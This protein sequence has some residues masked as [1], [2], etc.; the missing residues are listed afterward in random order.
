MS[1]DEVREPGRE[2][3]SVD[4]CIVKA[5]LAREA[6]GRNPTDREKKRDETQFGRRITQITRGRNA[7][8]GEQA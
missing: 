8:R 3:Q 7:Q 6:V 2:Q 5:P 4:G 1:C